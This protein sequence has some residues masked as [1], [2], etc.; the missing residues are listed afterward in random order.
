M[1]ECGWVGLDLTL[2]KP[3]GP[4][5]VRIAYGH[6]YS[7]VAP[8]R[9]VYKGHAGQRLSVDMRVRSAIDDDGRE[10]LSENKVVR[11]EAAVTLERAQ[12]PAQQQQ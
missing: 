4:Q 6:T 11:S 2:G 1:P 9:R 10:Q 7:D 5:H 12:Q 3:L 8:V